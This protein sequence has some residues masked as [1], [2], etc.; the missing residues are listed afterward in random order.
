MRP[1]SLIFM[2][3]LLLACGCAT[4]QHAAFQSPSYQAV[5]SVPAGSNERTTIYEYPANPCGT[6][7]TDFTAPGSVRLG[8]G[9]V[10]GQALEECHIINPAWVPND[11]SVRVLRCENRRDT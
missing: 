3:P 1:P 8:R 11:F 7:M 4:T 9:P 6:L 2:I 5:S 10:Y